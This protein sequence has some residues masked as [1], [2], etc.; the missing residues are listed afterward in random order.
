MVF[1][2]E[3]IT[4]NTLQNYYMSRMRVNCSILRNLSRP[5]HHKNTTDVGLQEDTEFS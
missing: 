1:F 5:F 4:F 2:E 3:F